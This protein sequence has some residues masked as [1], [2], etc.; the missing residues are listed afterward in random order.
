MNI[1]SGSDTR[2]VGYD[3]LTDQ[4]L[5]I[6]AG[7]NLGIEAVRS[8]SQGLT[9]GCNHRYT[10]AL[11]SDEAVHPIPLLHPYQQLT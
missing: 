10:N 9:S 5:D 11:A 1:Q 3:V 4:R 7:G 8:P 2:I 6:N